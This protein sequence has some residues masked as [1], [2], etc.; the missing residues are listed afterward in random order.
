MMKKFAGGVIV[1]TIVGATMGMLIDPIND[2]THRKME[3]QTCNMFRNIGTAMD[4][5]MSMWM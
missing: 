4:N 1:G 5:I 3:K 2:K